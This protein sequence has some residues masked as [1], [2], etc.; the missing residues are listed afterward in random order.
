MAY[1]TDAR[2]QISKVSADDL[3]VT[4]LEITHDDLPAPVRVVNDRQDIVFETNTYIA[5]GFRIAM[6]SDLQKGLPQATLGIDNV[7]RE[8]IEWLEASNG[9]QGTL[10]RIV[11]VLR[12]AP[13]VAEIDITM[14]LSNIQV[15]PLEVTGSLGFDDLL[16]IPAVVV[17]YTPSLAPGLF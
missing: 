14:T 3:P 4:L 10:V 13:S 17:Q 6:P 15:N 11:Q 16:N 1:S 9:G 5:L 2:K 7:G 12:S 8:L